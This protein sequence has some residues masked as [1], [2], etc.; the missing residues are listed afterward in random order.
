MLLDMHAPDGPEAVPTSCPRTQAY[1]RE[2]ALLVGLL[3]VGMAQGSFRQ[4]DPLPMAAALMELLH[5][6]ACDRLRRSLGLSNM[7]AAEQLTRL[8][9]GGICA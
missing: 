3:R 7:E 2:R 8:V 9:L 6:Q 5:W 1:L 4:G